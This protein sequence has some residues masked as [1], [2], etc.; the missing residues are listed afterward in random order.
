M[1]MSKAEAFLYLFGILDERWFITKDDQIGQL[2]SEL[3]P[4]GREEDSLITS[5][6]ASWSNWEASIKKITTNE[7]ITRIQAVKALV[8]LMKEYN[9][10]GFHLQ[11]VIDHFQIDLIPPGAR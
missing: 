4:V 9:K 1:L 10:Q 5:D 11:E 7:Q 8:E 3:N 6:P 2:C